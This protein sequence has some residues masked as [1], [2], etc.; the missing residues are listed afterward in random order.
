MDNFSN[1][2]LS[3]EEKRDIIAY[4]QSLRDQPRLRRLRPRR[5]RP[6][7]RGPLRLARRHRRPGRR[8]GL[9]RRPHGPDVQDEGR[10]MSDDEPPTSRSTA[11]AAPATRRRADRRTPALEPHQWRPTDVDPK[12]EKRAERQVAGLFVLAMVGAVL[13]RRLLLRLPDRRRLP[14]PSAGSAPPTS[15]SGVC[16]AV[17]LLAIGVG[18]HPVGAQAD[19]RPRDRRD[20]PHRR[21]LRGGPRGDASASSRPASRSPAS[22]AVR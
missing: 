1:G 13:L 10:R 6:G 14:T 3:P 21:L 18:H 9:D 2:N 16:L 4:L 5:H 15:R 20:A 19:G 7:E 8:R 17:T 12:A 22:A 11:T